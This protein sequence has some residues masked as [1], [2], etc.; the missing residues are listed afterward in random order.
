LPEAIEQLAK[1]P[2][3]RLV[4]VTILVG[5]PVVAC[6]HDASSGLLRIEPLA[7]DGN[8]PVPPLERLCNSC[9]DMAVGGGEQ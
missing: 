8:A 5:A 9:H 6:L 4:G 2:L 3:Q 1:P 7:V